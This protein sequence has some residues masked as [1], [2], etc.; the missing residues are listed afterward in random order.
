MKGIDGLE[1]E[2]L[3]EFIGG[4]YYK[5]E[6]EIYLERMANTGLISFGYDPEEDKTT[7]KTTS[8]GRVSIL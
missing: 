4:G 8:L 3:K 7:V 1:G 5:Q 6:Y 2:I